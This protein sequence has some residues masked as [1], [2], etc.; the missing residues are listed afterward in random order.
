MRLKQRRTRQL[1][2]PI[3]QG[4]H[5]FALLRLTTLLLTGFKVIRDS[6]LTG[7]M[8]EMLQD[9]RDLQCAYNFIGIST[10]V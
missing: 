10:F 5:L 9:I 1:L 3:F 8:L 6:T 7:E 4:S 2:Y